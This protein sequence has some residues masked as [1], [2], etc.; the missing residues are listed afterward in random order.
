MRVLG[1][2]GT[3]PLE[4]GTLLAT[5]LASDPPRTVALTLVPEQQPISSCECFVGSCTFTVS[6]VYWYLIVWRDAIILREP[7]EVVLTDCS[8]VSR[9]SD[10][11]IKAGRMKV[12]KGQ[13]IRLSLERARDEGHIPLTPWNARR[14][15]E[16]L[17]PDRYDEAGR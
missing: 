9:D 7:F 4:E 5:S 16:Y 12:S 17:C 8:R 10:P 13:D 3:L 2:R 6:R 11:S 15:A 1:A 14:I